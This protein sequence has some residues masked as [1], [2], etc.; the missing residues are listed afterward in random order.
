[1]GIGNH[2]GSRVGNR[3]GRLGLSRRRAG[4]LSAELLAKFL[5]L[6]TGKYDGD[7]LL[8]DL[9][10]D[11]ITVRG[12]EWFLPSLDELQAMY[13]QLYSYDIGDFDGELY[14][15]SS[16]EYNATQA[17]TIDFSANDQ[18]AEAKS[19]SSTLIRACRSFTAA[20]GT[21]SLRDEG[22]AGGW[23]FHID[24]TTYYECYPTDIG[25]FVWS[26]T[27]DE[28]IG[29]TARGTAI[30]TGAGNTNAIILQDADECAAEACNNLTPLKDWL[31]KV[32]PD[33]TAA[34][35]TVPDNATYIAADV[36]EDAWMT[37]LAPGD[38]SFW[39]SNGTLTPM[40]FED[41]ISSNTS[42]TFIK[43]TDFAPYEISAI[44][45]LKADAVLTEADKIELTRYFKL[46][47][48]Y[49]GYTMMDSGYM[50]DNRILLEGF[51]DVVIGTQTWKGAN[52][53]DNI[54]NSRVYDDDEDNRAIYGGLYSW[55][56]IAAI[57]ALHPGYHVPTNAEYGTLIT[58]LG[59][60][61]IA[62]GPLKDNSL[63]YWDQPNVGATNDSNFRLLPGGIYDTNMS[64]YQGLGNSGYL[65]TAT[66]FDAANA[67]MIGAYNVNATI[68]N[69]SLPKED[70]YAVRLI[71]DAAP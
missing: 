21:Y 15:W 45:I 67:Y 10:T 46:W 9:S 4:G 19:S 70:F 32:I 48:Q 23:I 31:T 50:K 12:V 66:E 16:S 49:W 37:D 58:F 26:S 61:S 63:L 17:Y 11:V 44:G 38:E 27:D 40:D 36:I 60:A 62:S 33:T 7:D 34:T 24:G 25:P 2:I 52:V 30:G 65:W 71:K 64:D 42:R 5:F 39:F 14:Y 6:W 69:A 43:Y 57:E 59:G 13:D 47:T 28:A 56:M 35:F 8:S 68:T 51:D 53:S 55:D 1:M 3:L 29:V 18:T 41:L 22:P 20:V 54:L